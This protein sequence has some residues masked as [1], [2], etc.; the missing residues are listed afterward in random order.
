YA[1]FG[2]LYA[3][4][5]AI[6]CVAAV[7][8]RL[9]VSRPVQHVFAAAAMAVAV[10]VVR[11]KRAQHRDDYQAD[12]YGWLQG[13]AAA[14]VYAALNL[15]IPSGWHGSRGLFYWSTYAAVWILPFVALTLAIREKDRELLDAGIALALATLITN[16]PYL[17]WPRHTWDPI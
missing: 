10:A 12:S 13:A 4:L 5:G 6:A 2:Y 1:R 9:D 3:A 7:P 17:G 16:K 15:Q 14:G 11:M 8:F